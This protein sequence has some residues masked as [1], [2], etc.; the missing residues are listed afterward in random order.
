MGDTTAQVEQVEQTGKRRGGHGGIIALALVLVALVVGAAYYQ[1]ELSNYWRLRGWDS[2]AVR[3]T[4]E[5]FVREAYDGQPSAGELLNPSWAQPKLEGGKF[6]G[7]TQ[8]SARGPSVTR[9]QAFVP[10]RSIKA[11]SVRIK[12]RSG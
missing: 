5:R 2:G 9:V 11:C 7:V 12:N 4:M 1:E 8:S 3:Q 6:I 10:D